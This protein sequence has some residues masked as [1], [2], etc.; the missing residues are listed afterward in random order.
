[1][2]QWIG[3]ATAALTGAILAVM[4]PVAAWAQ[5]TPGVKEVAEVG[6]VLAKYRPSRGGGG[7]IGLIGGGIICCLIV[8]VGIIVLVVFLVKRNK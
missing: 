3:R 2:K 6:G 5:A 4:L 7:S 8:V 1:M